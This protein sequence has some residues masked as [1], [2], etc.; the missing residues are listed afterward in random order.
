MVCGGGL[1]GAGV[2][3]GMVATVSGRLTLVG[4]ATGRVEL[5]VTGLAVAMGV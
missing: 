3:R 4:V 5:L 1:G 2:G